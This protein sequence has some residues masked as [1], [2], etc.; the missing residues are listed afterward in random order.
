MTRTTRRPRRV[1]AAILFSTL[2]APLAHAQQ[3]DECPRLPGDAELSWTQRSSEAFLICRAIGADGREAF[4]LYLAGNSPFQPARANR[5]ERGMVAGQ[6]IRWYR[7]EVAA[8]PSTLVRETLVELDNGQVMHVW[9]HARNAEQLQYNQRLV[10]SLRF[11]EAR[12]T[13]K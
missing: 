6:E 9:L 1:A 13:A 12:F 3:G 4:G 8:D 11:E 5:E 2:F 7:G 10:E